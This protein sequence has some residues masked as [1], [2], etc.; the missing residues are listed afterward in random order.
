MFRRDFLIGAAASSARV[1]FGRAA[2]SRKERV[3]RA[4]TGEDV[5]RP[6]FTFWHHFGLKTAE[7]H[8]ARTLEFHRLYHTDLVKVMSDFP[9]P[10]PPGKWHELKVNPNPFPDQIRALELIRDGLNGDAYMI[11]TVFNPW[12]VAEK[13]SSKQEVLHLK[14]QNPQALLDALDVITQTEIAHAKRALATG[15]SGILFSVANANSGEL[16]AADYQKFSRPFDQRF[17]ESVSGA[18]LNFLHLHVEPG[19]L[20]QFQGFTGAVIN[21]SQHVSRIPMAEVRRQFPAAVLAGGIDEVN[22]RKL[23]A[24]DM[25]KQW[26]AASQAAGRKFILTPGCSVPNDSAPEELARLPKLLGA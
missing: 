13:L 14:E 2:L 25:G 9:Y 19:Y 18:R 22:Y 15:A 16:S 10:K 6:P 5:D 17:M 4:L 12:N 26:R 11:E 7:A 24:D 1:V 21:Y 3:D 8:A 20:T 23:T